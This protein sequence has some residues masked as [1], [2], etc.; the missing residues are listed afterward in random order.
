MN[1]ILFLCL[2]PSP[3]DLPAA[4]ASLPSSFLLNTPFL[5]RTAG[6]SQGME[7]APSLLAPRQ[8]PAELSLCPL[9]GAL[10]AEKGAI[11]PE[12]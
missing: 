3:C 1:K 10:P 9:E 4:A 5:V 12:I 8:S 11:R 6:E 7:L 2:S